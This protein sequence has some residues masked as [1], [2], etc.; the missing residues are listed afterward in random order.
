[1]R[2]NKDSPLRKGY[3]LVPVTKKSFVVLDQG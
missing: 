1:M 2:N 3:L